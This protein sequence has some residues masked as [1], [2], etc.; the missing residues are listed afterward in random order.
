VYITDRPLAS[1]YA[2]CAAVAWLT[3]VPAAAHLFVTIETVFH[4]RFRA[5]FV[6]LHAG[7]SLAELERMARDL[8]LEVM[9][10]LRDTAS[11]QAGMTLMALMAAPTLV[12]ALSLPTDRAV[13]LSWLLVGAGLQMLAVAGTLLLYYFDFR[14]EALMTALVQL[15]ANGLL[16]LEF[17]ALGAAPGPGYAVACAL[18][19]GASLLFLHRRTIGLLER[20]FQSQPCASE[21]GALEAEVT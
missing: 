15:V 5:Y 12:R 18:T 1:T 21:S 16:T 11:V 20:T 10:T 14:R 9:R 6:A 17:A 2:A 7:A 4:R 19:C 3:V 8:R 13:L